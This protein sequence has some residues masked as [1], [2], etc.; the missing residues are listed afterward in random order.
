MGDI[1]M[2]PWPIAVYLDSG[3]DGGWEE[4]RYWGDGRWPITVHGDKTRPDGTNGAG[5]HCTVHYSTVYT[6]YGT[7]Y[8]VY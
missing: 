5:M 7:L 2:L 3:E 1:L 8:S 4:G 6:V